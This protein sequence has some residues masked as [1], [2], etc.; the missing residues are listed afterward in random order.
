M[1]LTRI[2]T[3]PRRRAPIPEGPTTEVLVAA[4]TSSLAGRVGRGRS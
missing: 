1:Y 3:N 2:G 4:E